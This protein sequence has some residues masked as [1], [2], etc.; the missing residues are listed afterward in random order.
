MGLGGCR[1][2]N[3]PQRE[4]ERERGAHLLRTR[5]LDILLGGDGNHF[6]I[7]HLLYTRCLAPYTANDVL[8]SSCSNYH[9]YGAPFVTSR[10][11]STEYNS[12]RQNTISS[13]RIQ[14]CRT[15][16]N[17]VRQNTILSDRIQFCQTEYNSVRQNT[18]LSNNSVGQN[19][20]LSTEY[21]SVQQN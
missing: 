9:G 15:E 16:Y 14:F 4:R 10:I 12:V 7:P 13:D 20:I 17:S 18:I 11:L 6:L 8:T 19:C 1:L 2:I 3:D 5:P 21:N